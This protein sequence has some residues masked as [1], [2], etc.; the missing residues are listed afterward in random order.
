MEVNNPP[1]VTEKN[2]VS[3]TNELMHFDCENTSLSRQVTQ[4][5]PS[6]GSICESENDNTDDFQEN[7]CS[8]TTRK[9]VTFGPA[10]KNDEK[11]LE[12]YQKDVMKRRIHQLVEECFEDMKK[13]S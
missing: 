12:N 8:N 2:R 5:K 3:D 13:D 4:V 1:T 9:R 7:G 6:L 10:K 11:S